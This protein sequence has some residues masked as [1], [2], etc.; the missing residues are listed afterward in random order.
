M[1]WRKSRGKNKYP[2]TKILKRGR[3]GVAVNI[4]DCGSP[5]PGSNPG[6]GPSAVAISCAGDGSADGYGR[7]HR[8]RYRPATEGPAR[9]QVG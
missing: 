4:G 8:H 9:L 5:D 7:D 3:G 1:S 6:L 2:E